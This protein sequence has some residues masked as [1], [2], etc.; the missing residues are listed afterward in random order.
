MDVSKPEEWTV[1]ANDAVKLSLYGP[2]GVEI[3]SFHPSYT[4][5]VFGDAETMYGH[6]GLTVNLE[7]AAW[8]MRTYLDISWKQR[9]QDADD[10]DAI[11]KEY[12]PE[13][14]RQLMLY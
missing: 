10:I 2:N 13:G 8:D 5:P 12:L 6:K 1:D 7:F 9:L 11:L 14:K 3:V 4:Y